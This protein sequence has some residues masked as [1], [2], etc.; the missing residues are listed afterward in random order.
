MRVNKAIRA[1]EIRV[2][3]AD[4]NQIGI[5]PLQEA[6]K[7]AGEKGLDLVEVAAEAEPPVCRIMNY[8][9]Y[10]YEQ[11]KKVHQ[12]HRKEKRGGVKEIK[13]RPRIEE[14]DYQV[15]LRHAQEF[16][17]AGHRLKV[18]VVFYGREGS[19]RDIGRKILERLSSDLVTSGQVEGAFREEGASITL[20]IVPK[21]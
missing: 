7:L 2:I 16:L 1:R 10:K 6:L 13:M 4:N 17:N 12:A 8:G 20:D 14:H 15:K 5:V 19:H 3:G 9:K 21:S 18:T 11:S